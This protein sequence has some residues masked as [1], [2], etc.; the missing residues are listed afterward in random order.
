MALR[1]YRRLLKARLNA[2]RGD[3]EALRQ[4]RLVIREQFQTNRNETNQAKLRN[5]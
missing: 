3:S 5:I 4:S 1:G 2:F